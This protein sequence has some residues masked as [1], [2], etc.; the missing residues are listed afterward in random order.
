MHPRTGPFLPHGAHEHP[1][2]APCMKIRVH[3][4]VCAP[5]VPYLPRDVP[6]SMVPL[7][8]T[9]RAGCRSAHLEAAP[10]SHW[11]I[12]HET[13]A[14]PIAKCAGTSAL[15]ICAHQNLA[16]TYSAC[17]RSHEFGAAS[18]PRCFRYT[19]LGSTRAIAQK[20]KSSVH[21]R[22]EANITQNVRK[23]KRKM[24]AHSD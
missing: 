22:P 12:L 3:V 10:S 11:R 9:K 13:P 7:C 14:A 4:F 5:G 19:T 21:S 6:L 8:N 2:E 24:S 17:I 20:P 1:P 18:T 16:S 23:R 15:P